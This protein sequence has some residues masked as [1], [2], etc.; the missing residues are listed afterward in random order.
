MQSNAEQDPSATPIAT[1]GHLAAWVDVPGRTAGD[2]MRTLEVY[3]T[4]RGARPLKQGPS[5]A[6]WAEDEDEVERQGVPTV[7]LN[8]AF[9]IDSQ[10]M[11]DQ[12]WARQRSMASFIEVDRSQPAW[13][14]PHL[15][16]YALPELGGGEAPYPLMLW[17]ALLY[18]LSSLARY[19]PA[20]WTQAVDR[21]RSALAVPLE[22]VL[23]RAA[24]R[25]PERVHDAV[26]PT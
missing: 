16:G 2:V 26:Q 19:E 20:A 9:E 6:V 5:G 17:W 15:I 12:F 14:A 13:P 24:E 10:L 25:V 4:L 18:G 11:I 21:D 22:R 8:V 7:G 23:D 3:P 1:G